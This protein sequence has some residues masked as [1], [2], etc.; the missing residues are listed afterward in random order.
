MNELLLS[1]FYKLKTESHRNLI[2]FSVLIASISQMK[3]W[4]Q[5]RLSDWPIQMQNDKK[6]GEPRFTPYMFCF[7]VYTL[8]KINTT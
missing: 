6:V 7:N 1:L 4:I 5:R 8:Q 2:I 3:N